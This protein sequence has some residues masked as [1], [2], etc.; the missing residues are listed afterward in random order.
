MVQ[1]HPEAQNGFF[2]AKESVFCIL[3]RLVFI[4]NHSGELDKITMG[5]VEKP[6][7]NKFFTTKDYSELCVMEN[8]YLQM[9]A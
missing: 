1:A 6:W 4:L 7:G 3:T 8:D 2:L 5:S 9:L